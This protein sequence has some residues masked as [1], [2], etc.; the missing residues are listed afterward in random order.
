MTRLS[1]TQ[2]VVLSAASQRDNQLVL[3]LPKRL[4]GGAARKVIEALIAKG[5]VVEADAD[6]RRGD[7]V[8]RELPDGGGMTLVITEAGLAALDGGTAPAAADAGTPATKAR[9]TGK[10][11]PAPRQARGSGITRKATAA[12]AATAAVR[13]GT[14]QARLIAM[15]QRPKGATIAEIAETLAWQAH[16]VRGAIAGVLKKKLGLAVVS[17]TDDKRG[18]IYRIG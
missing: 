14:K 2:L 15:L 16:T 10:P 17:E 6:P 3:P 13:S 1:D 7:P 18:R 5:L 9:N 8:W 4:K 12:T 11:V